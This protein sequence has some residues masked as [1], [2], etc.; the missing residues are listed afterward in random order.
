MI[1]G[2]LLTLGKI[3]YPPEKTPISA[4]ETPNLL[5]RALSGEPVRVQSCNREGIGVGGFRVKASTVTPQGAERD[6]PDPRPWTVQGVYLDTP[7][8]NRVKV[9]TL[10]RDTP[11]RQ[12]VTVQPSTETPQTGTGRQSGPPT[13][14]LQTLNRDGQSVGGRGAKVPTATVESETPLHPDP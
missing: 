11:D 12:P 3:V 5:L 8:Y 7:G 9:R 2:D 14:T 4:R 13:E 6:S 10:D 1:L